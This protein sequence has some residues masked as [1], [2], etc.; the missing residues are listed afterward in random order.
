MAP[1]IP[2]RLAQLED[3][4]DRDELQED[5][6]PQEVVEVRQH[7]GERPQE[8]EAGQPEQFRIFFCA[9]AER[10]DLDEVL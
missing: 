6:M 10:V 1:A 4:L 9:E 3:A 8:A 5:V 2:L 7:L